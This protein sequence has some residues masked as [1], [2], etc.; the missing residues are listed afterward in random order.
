MS[1]NQQPPQPPSDPPERELAAPT[2][3]DDEFRSTMREWILQEMRKLSKDCDEINR[4]NACAG[5]MRWFKAQD[6]TDSIKVLEKLLAQ[7]KW[8]YFRWL[9]MR[10]MDKPQCVEWAIYCAEQV[11]GIYEKKYPDDDRPRKA[12]EAAKAY[13]A[14]PC[15]ATKKA[16]AA[17]AAADAAAAAYAADADSR[18]Q[19]R[20]TLAKFA[21]EIL[22]KASEQ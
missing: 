16:S 15:D 7:D 22:Q 3:S 21:I 19:M 18:K 9:V 1:A 5:G 10:L 4:Q 8:D 2:C 11:I 13:L 14:S 12:I 6:E 20:N 17:D